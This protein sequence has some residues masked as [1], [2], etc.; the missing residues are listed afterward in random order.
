MD[1]I[2][3]IILF[4]QEKFDLIDDISNIIEALQLWKKLW[5]FV[6]ISKIKTEERD[7]YQLAISQYNLNA[8][9]FYEVGTKYFSTGV[10]TGN[11]ETFYMHVLRS[12]IP[13]IAHITFDKHSIGVGIF[14][15]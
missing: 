12:Y 15:M 2:P 10:N 5:L 6:S 11:E 7:A 14:N 4:I 8:K 13:K 1:N 9:R 3:P